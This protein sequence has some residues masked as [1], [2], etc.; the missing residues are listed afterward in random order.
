MASEHDSGDACLFRSLQ[1]PLE[2]GEVLIPPKAVR[3]SGIRAER[4]IDA[5]QG[6]GRLANQSVCGERRNDLEPGTLQRSFGF[7]RQ[8]SWVSRKQD[9][10]ASLLVPARGRAHLERPSR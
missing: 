1:K 7:R 10:Y 5:A 8:R 4:K 6:P 9:R 2:I 3:P